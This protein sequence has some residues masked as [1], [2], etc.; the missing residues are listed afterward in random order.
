MRS[1][2]GQ[3]RGRFARGLSHASIG[4]E[5]GASVGVGY[6]IGMKLDA[7]FGTSWLMIT[8]TL[9]GVVAGFRAL[10]KLTLKLQREAALEEGSDESEGRP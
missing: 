1:E 7:Y 9:L 4:I 5:M 10:L 6:W 8:F 3:G 2:R